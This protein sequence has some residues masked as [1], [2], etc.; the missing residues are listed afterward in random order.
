[1]HVKWMRREGIVTEIT[2]L[3]AD[4]QWEDVVGTIGHASF[5]QFSL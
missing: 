5:I 3:V 4:D 2:R 1:M